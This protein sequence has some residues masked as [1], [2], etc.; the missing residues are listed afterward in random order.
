MSVVTT[1]QAEGLRRI[2]DQGVGAVLWQREW[3]QARVDE[4][5]QI[6]ANDLPNGRWLVPSKQPSQA[7]TGVSLSSWLEADVAEL[8]AIFAELMQV[9]QVRLRFDAINTNA[10]RR[11]HIDAVKARLLCTY[12]GHGTEFGIVE[13]DG[14]APKGVQTAAI[15]SP[16]ILRGICWPDGG[17]YNAVRHRSPPIEGTGE[18]RLL[19]VLDT[20]RPDT[21][22]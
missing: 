20:P 1:T 7:L 21:T 5:A 10:C 15:G 2:A 16:L 22:S 3:A 13:T 6:P 17:S 19:L 14:E 4:V 8:V 12:R 18:T 11:F 9:N